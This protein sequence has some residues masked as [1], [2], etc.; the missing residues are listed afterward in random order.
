MLHRQGLLLVWGGALY[1]QGKVPEEEVALVIHHLIPE[2][3]AVSCLVCHVSCAEYV[4]SFGAC[5]CS[6]SNS[7]FFSIFL[8]VILG[9]EIKVET[10]TDTFRSRTNAFAM[11]E[12]DVL[13][14]AVTAV[15][16]LPE[17]SGFGNGTMNVLQ[18]VCVFSPICPGVT[19]IPFRR[20]IRSRISEARPAI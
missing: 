6:S 2:G 3:A 10:A 5:G 20:K 15:M 1:H 8:I 7:S 17:A 13:D 18:Q 16:A 12:A 9:I 19:W 14:R 4:R 11:T